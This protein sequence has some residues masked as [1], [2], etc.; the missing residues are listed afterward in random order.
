MSKIDVNGPIAHPLDKWL[1]SQARDK[2]ANLAKD[3]EAA[4]S[5]R[6]VAARSKPTF[7]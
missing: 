3:I 5:V 4:G 7:G 6:P 2:P 1:C